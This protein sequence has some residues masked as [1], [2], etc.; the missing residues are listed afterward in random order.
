[1]AWNEPGGNRDDD[2]WGPRKKK[3]GPP[4]LDEVFKNIK[5]KIS[6]WLGGGKGGSGSSSGSGSGGGGI[7]ITAL[8]VI[9]AVVWAGT[10]FYTVD[11]SQRA[12]VQRFGVPAK[13]TVG[14]GLHWHLP[15]PIEK[16][17]VVDV[18]KNRKIDLSA[19]M[20]T[21]DEKLVK[22]NI[23]V[24]YSVNADED[25]E[26]GTSG[27][28]DYLFKVKSYDVK[29]GPKKTLEEAL[30]SALR[31]VLST[32]KL[33]EILG[34]QKVGAAKSKSR[35]S[36]CNIQYS[37]DP[38]VRQHNLPEK[39]E[40]G[41]KV[42][43]AGNKAFVVKAIEPLIVSEFK[44]IISRYNTGFVIN[45]VNIQRPEPPT[46]AVD[47]AFKDVTKAQ[48][49]ATRYVEAAWGFCQKI[50][51]IANGEKDRILTDAQAYKQ[52]KILDAKG[53]TSRFKQILVEYERAPE[54][55]RKRLFLETKEK[56]LAKSTM[57]F[58][59]SKSNGNVLFLPLNQYLNSQLNAQPG[60]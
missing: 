27:L 56:V 53:E 4:D 14:P 15:Y 23:N 59:R 29:E 26:K 40:N 46:R 6:G 43:A 25:I 3:E 20:L 5:K 41:K 60:K 52:R 34:Q 45:S 30:I 57:V 7:G 42:K 16:V 12:I 31:E 39:S 1:M 58:I 21:K 13:N 50:V 10:G 38:I 37:D 54:I 11:S 17:T 35:L 32:L 9:A 44:R 19:T 24:N 51:N 28:K 18:R 8:I 47:D 48:E 36:Q 55:T 22:I 33:E 2:P 49:D